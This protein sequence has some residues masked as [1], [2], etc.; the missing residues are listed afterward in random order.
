MGKDR[1]KRDS[2]DSFYGRFLHEQVVPKDDFLVKL[3]EITPWQ[4]FT[5]KLIKYYKGRT[6]LPQTGDSSKR[7]LS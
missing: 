2:S 4:R 3:N 1:F 5:Y 6:D 7:S